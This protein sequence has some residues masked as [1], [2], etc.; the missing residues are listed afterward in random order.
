MALNRY[1]YIEGKNLLLNTW[2]VCVVTYLLLVVCRE[3]R[4]Q[5]LQAAED[6]T[7]QVNHIRYRVHSALIIYTLQNG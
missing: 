7:A 1:T 6:L 2:T 4:V 3:L 5:F